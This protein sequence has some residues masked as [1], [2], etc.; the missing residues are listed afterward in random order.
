M[1]SSV[2]CRKEILT[3]L[4]A[5]PVGARVFVC[6][7]TRPDG[8]AIGS[9]LAL[10]RALELRGIEASAV[11]ADNAKRAPTPYHWM[12]GCEN[13]LRPDQLTGQKA[14]VFI[15]LDTPD[16]TRINEAGELLKAAKLSII[17]DHHP[18]LPESYADLRYVE[19]DASAT[20]KIVWS[21][22]GDLGW[23]RDK[24]VATACYVAT[25][26]DTGSFQFSNTT[27][28][29]FTAVA[30]MIDAGANPT[31]IAQQLYNQ[32]PIA[33]LHLEGRIL[34]RAKLLNGGAVV[35]SYL[36][37]ADLQELGVEIDYTE[38]LID[39]IRSTRN[40]DVALFITESS[41]G[42]R[43][44]LRSDGRFDVSE[45]ARQFGGGGHR[46]AAG[47][48]WPD[49]TASLEQILDELLPMLPMR[50]EEIEVTHNKEWKIVDMPATE[51][52]EEDAFEI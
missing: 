46:P 43:L 37:D 42:P 13:Y 41:K 39:L 24:D 9:T 15:A 14:D 38:N 18:P 19:E 50:D 47:I 32:K 48:T 49:K 28:Q 33:A 7:H 22:L 23:T 20:G 5:I 21:L 12:T 4:S 34:S 11:L 26:S 27:K 3:A 1:G 8:D 52:T 40:T 2:P 10:V 51:K 44:S 31:K 36:S 25:I 16:F 35:H 6:G 17:I 45:V 29:A 30:E